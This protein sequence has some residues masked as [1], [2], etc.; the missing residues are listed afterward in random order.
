MGPHVFDDF[1]VR[2]VNVKEGRKVPLVS[3]SSLDELALAGVAPPC[4]ALRF[5]KPAIAAT[6]PMC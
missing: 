4:V 2:V 5:A 3:G 6:M 1:Q